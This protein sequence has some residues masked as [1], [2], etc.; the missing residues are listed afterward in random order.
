MVSG[1]ASKQFS[2][3]LEGVGKRAACL[4]APVDPKDIDGECVRQRK[5]R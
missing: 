2:L 4:R 3:E 5:Y 1:V